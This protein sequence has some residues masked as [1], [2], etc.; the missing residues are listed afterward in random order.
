MRWRDGIFQEV[1]RPSYT[2]TAPTRLIHWLACFEVYDTPAT[3]ISLTLSDPIRFQFVVNFILRLFLK[4]FRLPIFYSIWF[5]F[6]SSSPISPFLLY[7]LFSPLELFLSSSS[8]CHYY[9]PPIPPIL[10]FL[11]LLLFLLMSFFS[12]ILPLLLCFLSSVS[13]L[14]FLFSFFSILSSPSFL[15]SLFSLF[16][17]HLILSST[18]FSSYSSFPL[19]LPSSAWIIPFLLFPLPLLSSSYS[20]SPPSSRF[21]HLLFLTFLLFF[22]MSFSLSNS[23]PFLSSSCSSF[24]PS[25]LLLL[26]FLYS[27]ISSSFS[28]SSPLS[29]HFSLESCPEGLCGQ[30][31]VRGAGC[32]VK[33]ADVVTPRDNLVLPVNP[34]ISL[35]GNCLFGYAQPET[36]VTS[37]GITHFVELCPSSVAIR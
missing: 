22:R 11:T 35:I 3:V 27:R 15:S 36:E 26:I 23:S 13:S 21:L 2:D 8:L 17:L 7:F 12:P 5:C 14:F 28:H 30:G 33:Q 37:R 16:L 29:A 9:P 19:L 1:N 4:T 10:L 32:D 6:C 20:S 24:P 34:R 31:L 18:F 25:P